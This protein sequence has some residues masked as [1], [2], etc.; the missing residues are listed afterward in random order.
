MK[1][2]LFSILPIIIALTSFSQESSFP[3]SKG[4]KQFT[5]GLGV[6]NNTGAFSLLIPPIRAGL[7]IGIHDFISIEPFVGIS[8]DSYT[9]EIH[10]GEKEGYDPERNIKF[11]YDQDGRHTHTYFDFGAR[12]NCHW[13]NF[14]TGL[15]SELDL[16]S[17]I[18]VWFYI[19]FEDK[20]FTQKNYRLYNNHLYAD[21]PY[22]EFDE[23]EIDK[24]KLGMDIGFTL[25]GC[26][27]YFDDTW[28]LMGEIN[29]NN[30]TG[31]LGISDFLIGA[32]L[33]L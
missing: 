21:I 11:T 19:D 9:W 2:V 8:S 26:R 32:S 20:Y 27:W 7:D 29:L 28:A 4:S 1:R 13:G 15:P 14:I 24:N 12:I 18:P 30:Y 33:R 5:I 6:K 23:P 3:N 17:G 25:V 10:K 16:Y 22:K 31:S